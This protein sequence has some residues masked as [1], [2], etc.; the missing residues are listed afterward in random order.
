MGVRS[1]PCKYTE[2]T[3]YTFIVIIIITYVNY[4]CNLFY[5]VYLM[6]WDTTRIPLVRYLGRK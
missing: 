6:Y 5:T 3:E 1:I 2:S 4:P